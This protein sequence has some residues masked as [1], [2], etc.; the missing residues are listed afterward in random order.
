MTEAQRKLFRE[1]LRD[2]L[3]IQHRFSAEPVYGPTGKGFLKSEGV[4]TLQKIKQ[5]LHAKEK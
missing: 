5:N 2:G 1:V 3:K 4:E